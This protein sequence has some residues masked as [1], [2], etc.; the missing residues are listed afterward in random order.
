M[1][2]A[3]LGSARDSLMD[4]GIVVLAVHNEMIYQMKQFRQPDMAAVAFNAG[5]DIL[6]LQQAF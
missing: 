3:E 5:V 2:G 4:F 6:L 1:D